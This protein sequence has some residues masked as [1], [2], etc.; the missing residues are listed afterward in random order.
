[1]FH[2]DVSMWILSPSQAAVTQSTWHYGEYK[3]ATFEN[4]CADQT[5][6]RSQV[7]KCKKRG[8]ED[9]TSDGGFKRQRTAQNE[10]D[11][12]MTDVDFASE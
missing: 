2:E 11:S 1:M 3:D 4:W 8:A 5:L 9:Q 7:A 6:C 10:F 12:D